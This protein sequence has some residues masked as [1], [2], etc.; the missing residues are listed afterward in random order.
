MV[1]DL[2]VNRFHYLIFSRREEFQRWDSSLLPFQGVIFMIIKKF[3][4]GKSITDIKNRDIKILVKNWMPVIML[5]VGIGLIMIG[6]LV[7]KG[8][9]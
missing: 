4:S 7:E 2:Q 3:G 5:C 8:I 9:I 6:V 1:S